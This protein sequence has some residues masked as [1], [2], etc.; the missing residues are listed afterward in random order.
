MSPST[1]RDPAPL[2]NASTQFSQVLGLLYAQLQSV[3]LGPAPNVVPAGKNCSTQ[4][5]VLTGPAPVTFI[6][7]P[8]ALAVSELDTNVTSEPPRK[9]PAGDPTSV[10]PAC[11]ELAPL[12]TKKLPRSAILP[13]YVKQDVALAPQSFVVR[14]TATKVTLA[15]LVK[16]SSAQFPW[17]PESG[18]AW[19]VVVALALV[20]AMAV[21]GKAKP[22]THAAST[23]SPAVPALLRADHPRPV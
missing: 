8:V 17:L 11:G 14:S 23:A 10:T 19:N 12:M 7:T 3:S 1:G 2:L 21:P 20:T 15:V 5:V 9:G 16:S 13:A 22:A 6:G 18:C 4:L